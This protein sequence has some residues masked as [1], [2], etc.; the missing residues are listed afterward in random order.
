MSKLNLHKLRKWVWP[1]PWTF[2]CRLHALC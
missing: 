1:W 2:K